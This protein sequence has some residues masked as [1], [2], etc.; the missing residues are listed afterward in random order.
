[1]CGIVGYA[2]FKKKMTLAKALQAIHHRG[3][4]DHGAVYFD[5]VALGNARLAI[6]DVSKKGHQPMCTADGTLCITFNGEIYNFQEIKKILDKKYRFTSHTDTEVILCAYQEWGEHCVEKLHGMFSFVIFDRRKH[7]LFGARDRLGQK[8]LKYYFQNGQ[9]IFASEIKGILPLLENTPDVEPSAID[10]FLTLQ[11]V[12]TP[13]TGFKRIFKLPAGHYFIYKNDKL[14]IQRY[15][16]LD[17]NR[18]LNVSTDEW[19]SLVFNEIKRSVKS[20]LVS[21]VPVG[22]LL[23][24]GLDSSIVVALMSINSSRRV[25]TFSIGFDD[26]KFDET[27]FAKMVSKMYRTFHT[28]LRITSGDLMKNIKGVADVYDE[29]IGD[30][31]ILPTMLVTKLAST[32]VKVALTGDGGDENFAGYQRYIYVNLSRYI[33]KYPSVLK[34]AMQVNA[35]IAFKAHP[36]QLT[37]RMDRFTSSINNN[38]YRKYVHY[39]SFFTNEAKHSLYIDDFASAVKNNDTFESYR[40]MYDDKLSDLD[41]ALKIDI[42]TYLPDDLLYKSD[43]ASM[44]NGLELRAP[45]LD[46]VLMERIAAMPSN[47]KLTFTTKKKILKSVALKYKLLPKEVIHRRKQGFTIPQN[48]WFKG[49]LKEYLYDQILTSTMT[50]R[51]FDRRRLETYLDD[52]YRTNLNYDNNIFA[53]LMLSLWFD[54]YQ[55]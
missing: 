10:D 1:M 13:K 15:W 50:G 4:D 42:Y 44:A 14:T 39:N 37:E 18:K 30:N 41:N 32:K 27:P 55:S 34:Y 7:V 23:S 22:A 36:N 5:G 6:I 33:S 20:H 49:P 29:P 8:P 16:S 47:I 45:F 11:Y 46:H 52:Y 21:D 3:P 38:F 12:P 31:S 48:R 53:L 51:I 43:A 40:S 54:K 25:N 24:G 9:F 2:G 19:E 35:K 17:F 28:Q 26:E